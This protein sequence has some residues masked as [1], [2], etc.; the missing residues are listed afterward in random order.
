FLEKAKREENP[1]EI[2]NAYRNYMHNTEGSLSLMYA[3]SMVNAAHYF[4]DSLLISAAYLS[5]G[6]FYYGQ[7]NY[8]PALEHYLK[9]KHYL[10]TR[11]DPYLRYKIHYNI[12]QI[13]YYLGN[14]EEALPLLQGCIAYFRKENP[15]AY[16]NSLHSLA[17]CYNRM[18]DIG[19]SSETAQLGVTEGKRLSLDIME[20]YF[21]HVEGINH[22]FRDN[23]G[24]AI[25]VLSGTLPGIIQNKDF[26]NEAIGNFYLGK[27]YL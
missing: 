13:K 10:T 6:I 5:K 15:R 20:V 4:R 19:K 1:E 12:A 14:Y 18:G 16:L 24:T 21:H 25:E 11:D 22:Y 7:K 23:Y 27:S 26:A 3:D 9:A 8:S 2:V 17:L